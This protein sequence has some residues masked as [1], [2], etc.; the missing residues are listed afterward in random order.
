MSQCLLCTVARNTFSLKVHASTY[1]SHQEGKITGDRLSDNFPVQFSSPAA[2]VNDA[3]MCF[4]WPQHSNEYTT[5]FI[6]RHPKQKDVRPVSSRRKCLIFMSS[7]W[8]VNVLLRPCINYVILAGLVI[9][10]LPMLCSLW[11]KSAI[12]NIQTVSVSSEILA[13]VRDAFLPCSISAVPGSLQ[14]IR[15]MK[16]SQSVKSNLR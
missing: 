4:F 12:C 3:Y 10:G 8:Y 15:R 11:L 1:P 13:L 2:S 7:N 14:G 5:Y 9:A 6:F 16:S